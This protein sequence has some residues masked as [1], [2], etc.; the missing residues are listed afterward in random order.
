MGLRLGDLRG[1]VAQRVELASDRLHRRQLV[2][3]VALLRDQLVADLGGGQPCVQAVRAELRIDLALP[4]NDSGEVGQQVGQV[5]LRPLAP[6]QR[7]GV[8][9][10][11]PARQLAG[12]FADR[13]TAP[14]QRALGAPLPTRP[15]F[16]DG[17]RH[18]DAAGTPLERLGRLDEQH[19]ERVREFHPAP[20]RSSLW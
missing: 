3:G 17:P 18:E 2:V 7:E 11:K 6:A 20:S 15:Q 10:G 8:D 19:L 9:D 16:L 5:V 12:A 4:I 13:R 1:V 14:P